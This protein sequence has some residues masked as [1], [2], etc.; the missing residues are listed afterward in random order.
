VNWHYWARRLSAGLDSRAQERA[1]CELIERSGLFDRASYFTRLAENAE[2]PLDPI[3]HYLRRGARE[4]YNPNPFFEGDWYLARYPDV[5]A[6]GMNPLVHYLRYGAAEQRDPGPF[7]DTHWYFTQYPELSLQWQALRQAAFPPSVF[8]GDGGALEAPATSGG[9]QSLRLRE[10]LNPLGHYL[11]NGW[12]KGLLPFD[13]ARLLGGVKIAVIVHLFYADLWDEIDGKLHNVP[14]DFDLFVSVPQEKA[15]ELRTV[16]LRDRPLAKVIEVPNAGRDVGALFAVLPNVLAGNYSLICKLHSKKGPAYP[17]AW[18]D[19]LLRGVLANKMLVTRIIHAFVCNPELALVGAR[20]VYISGATQMLQNVPKLTQLMQLLCPGQSLPD[21]W[22]FFAGT[23]FWARPE[24]L[25]PIAQRTDDI[26]PFE[27]DNSA[28]DGQIAH[29][30]ERLFGILAAVNGKHIGLTENTGPGPVEGTIHVTKAPGHPWAGGFMPI[31]R[32]HAL[33]LS[34]ELPFG[35][36]PEPRFEIEGNLWSPLQKAIERLETPAYVAK[37]SATANARFP[38]GSRKIMQA[39]K[40]VGWLATLQL[41]PR[42]RDFFI[43]RMEAD[44]VASSPLFDAGWYLEVNADVRAAQ[45]D[46]ALHYVAHGAAQYRNPGPGFD[47]A[48]YLAYYPDVA[49]SGTNPLV[50]YLRHGMR[51]GRHALPSQ[52]VIGEVTDAV[53]L[54][55]KRPEAAKELALL[56]THS[57]DGLLKTHVRHYLE[58]LRRQGICPVLIVAADAEFCEP[59]NGLLDIVCGL[60]IRQNVGYDFAAWAH[61]LWQNPQLLDAECLYLLNDSVIGPLNEQKFANLLQRVRSSNSDVIGLTDSYERGWHIQSYFIVL[62][63]TA[64]SSPALRALIGKIKNLAAKADVV[65]AY[66]I[67]LAAM[68]RAA[69]LSCEVLF[70]TGKAYNSTLVDWRD[71]ISIGLPFVKTAALRISSANSGN[72][73]WQKA[74]QSEGFD[75]Q[76]AERALASRH[77]AQHQ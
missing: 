13:P 29:A 54:C 24:F 41:F 4:G 77:V 47:T 38:R 12:H 36:N 53:L 75:C 18:R 65:N 72:A 33:R 7:F 61:V 49:V 59:D 6:A 74:L 42:L 14:I 43:R 44:L 62:K 30:I 35:P 10:P 66:E 76:L 68:L 1:D 57:P 48:W 39:F 3:L 32:N 34:G 55:R 67:R 45:V 69:G 37:W 50:H 40:L 58:T 20:E 27:G 26:P 64:L 73:D 71:L 22:G 5:R 19:L 51:E 63:R 16:I 31:L 15:G 2:A 8:P 70:P 46:P 23:M 52:I 11:Q 28:N 60:Y 9:H 21:N 25:R 56:V 17:E